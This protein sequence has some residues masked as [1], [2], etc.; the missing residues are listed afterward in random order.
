MRL[1]DRNRGRDVL[2]KESCVPNFNRYTEPSVSKRP[3]R[4]FLIYI[5]LVKIQEGTSTCARTLL[6][7]NP[8]DCNQ[9]TTTVD[10]KYTT[11]SPRFNRITLGA[12]PNTPCTSAAT[13]SAYSSFFPRVTVTCVALRCTSPRRTPI[14]SASSLEYRLGITISRLT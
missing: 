9:R 13:Y 1:K 8:M 14:S 11:V 12:K 5:R 7:T 3:R 4:A 6:N 2:Q 10:P